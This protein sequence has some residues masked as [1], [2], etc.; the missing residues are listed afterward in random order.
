MMEA[1][2]VKALYEIMKSQTAGERVD[3]FNIERGKIEEFLAERGYGII[4]HYSAADMER[5]YL[6]LR[7]GSLDGKMTGHVCF[8]Y[9]S[10][11][12]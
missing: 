10:V 4:E 5:K 3:L 1:Y 11:A 8:A 12:G 6:T 9:A 2:G 7:G